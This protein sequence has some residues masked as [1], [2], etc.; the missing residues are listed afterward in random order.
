MVARVWFYD[1]DILRLY[2]HDTISML[3]QFICLRSSQLQYA[4]G[5]IIPA[6]H[7]QVELYLGCTD[8]LFELVY[9]NPSGMLLTSPQSC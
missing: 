1:R 6:D 8:R 7:A 2:R 5:N 3:R 4:G 9:W